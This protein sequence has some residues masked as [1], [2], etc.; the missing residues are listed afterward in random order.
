MKTA[1]KI[2][3]SLITVI[4]FLGLFLSLQGDQVAK[5]DYRISANPR[6]V[7]AI[8]NMFYEP[9]YFDITAYIP[10]LSD[11]KISQLLR[12]MSLEQKIGQMFIWRAQGTQMTEEYSSFLKSVDAGGVILMGDN[13]SPE[14]MRFTQ[15]IQSNSPSLPM[16]IS[17]DQEGGLVKRIISDPNPGALALA[18][19][20][21]IVF[22][23][24]IKKTS[25][26]LMSNG[27]NLNFGIVADI[28]W[29]KDSFI[30]GRSFGQ[31]PESV[32][33][34][35]GQAVVCTEKVL[36]TLKHF[37]GHGRTTSDSHQT[38]PK[39]DLL[40]PDWAKTDALPFI[41]GINKGSD[42]VMMGHLIYPSIGSEPAS[43]SKTHINNVR[44]FGFEGVVITDDM[45]MLEKSGLDP[46]ESLDKAIDAG[47]DVI[48]YVQ[49]SKDFKDLYRHTLERAK[50]GDIDSKRIDESVKR[51]LRKKVELLEQQGI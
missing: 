23:E 33:Y 25:D 34:R 32:S 17:I 26:I 44:N 41:N 1:Y 31:N 7:F 14:L 5:L 8:H 10:D 3:L 49:S 20:E 2:S 9:T 16:F 27:I 46:F 24:T 15:D 18:N 13:I 22:C 12:Q 6:R 29:Y 28:G 35:V 51:I 48:L 47:N 37:P 4:I 36:S 50:N 40:A 45:G 11:L 39:I 30:Y 38:L 43:L 21:D 19:E 42:F